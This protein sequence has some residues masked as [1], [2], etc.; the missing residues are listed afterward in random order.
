MSNL[1]L[2]LF[3]NSFKSGVIVVAVCASDSSSDDVILQD[4]KSPGIWRNVVLPKAAFL[5]EKCR[6]ADVG[7]WKAT[8]GRTFERNDRDT[9]VVM[10][11]G[12]R[13]VRSFAMVEVFELAR[14]K[15]CGAWRVEVNVWMM[16]RCVMGDE[17]WS[18]D[19][20][21]EDTSGLSDGRNT[22]SKIWIPT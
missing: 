22:V 11:A 16:V 8:I 18:A 9:T 2:F 21:E 12:S 17:W 15:V 6:R 3:S 19:A 14:W 10:I 4:T 13:D 5:E 7:A 1:N 20:L